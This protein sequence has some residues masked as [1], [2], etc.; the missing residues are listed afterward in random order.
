MFS[1]GPYSLGYSS[2]P[3]LQ[4][5][6]LPLNS[7]VLPLV[8]Y[9]LTNILSLS[10]ELSKGTS[11]PSTEGATACRGLNDVSCIIDCIE[12]YLYFNIQIFYKPV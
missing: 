2:V 1:T 7:A 4:T 6:G 3:E 11:N 5:C 8:C 9:K 12:A 10:S